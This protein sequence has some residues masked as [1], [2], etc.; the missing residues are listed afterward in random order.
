MKLAVI[1]LNLL[2]MFVLNAHSAIF[3]FDLNLSSQLDDN[4]TQ[5]NAAGTNHPFVHSTSAGL[6][7]NGG[8]TKGVAAAAGATS[9]VYDTSFAGNKDDFSFSFLWKSSNAEGA[10]LLMGVTNSASYTLNAGGVPLNGSLPQIGFQAN[11]GLNGISMTQYDGTASASSIASKS[12]SGLSTDTFYQAKFS[13]SYNSL[14][15]NYDLVLSVSTVDGSGNVLAEHDSITASDRSSALSED[16]STFLY[17]ATLEN[18]SVEL[19]NLSS[20]VFVPEPKA[21]SLLLGFISL[22]LVALRRR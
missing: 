16:S 10:N 3:T 21:Y 7:S 5:I 8:I 1:S 6:G 14:D 18:Y 4:F 15:A 13:Y 2:A 9:Y 17:F 11:V 19:D 12:M 20:S 22:G